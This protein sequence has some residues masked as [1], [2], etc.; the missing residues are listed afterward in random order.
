MTNELQP[1]PD[2]IAG[3]GASLR[4]WLTK[5]EPIND[6]TI[7]F[8]DG[9][10]HNV[11]RALWH[12]VQLP[13]TWPAAVD[14]LLATFSLAE[15]RGYWSE[16]LQLI[17]KALQTP[18]W[19]DITQQV[20]LLNRQGQ[21]YRLQWQMAQ[22]SDIH[23]TAVSLAAATQDP[24]LLAE[25]R[26]NLL[27]DWIREKKY[28]EAL[29][30]GARILD[31]FRRR[32]NDA[33]WTVQTLRPLGVAATQLG[34]YEQAI[35]YLTEAVS[36]ARTLVD[37]RL[38]ALTL[39]DLADARQQNEQ[40]SE[41]LACYQ[42]AAALLAPTSYMLDKAMTDLN[43]GTLHFRLKQLVQAEAAFQR[44]IDSGLRQ[45]GHV[46][47]RT[48]L[49]NNLGNV[50]FAQGKFPEAQA[51]LQ[52]ALE[53]WPQVG[54]ETGWGDTHGMMGLTLAAQGKPADARPHLEESIRLLSRHPE[55]KWA[56]KQLEKYR[57]AY[58]ELLAAGDA[59]S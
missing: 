6:D 26:W 7:Q 31:F 55:N 51:A 37:P 46:Y 36:I 33:W 12:G 15:R 14:L 1:S 50:R 3:I 56:Q 35:P 39:N 17:E 54:E 21:F 2:F 19:G 10:R 57:A 20:K 13:A 9:E 8:L 49:E 34:Q 43:L 32:Q 52:R 48:L 47:F 18:Q 28:P 44:A 38:L 11:H 30:E 16:W 4:Y 22:A 27:V 29:A 45:S 41:A 5:S 23:E 58:Q 25:A 24:M 42:E 40:T 59:S 53:L